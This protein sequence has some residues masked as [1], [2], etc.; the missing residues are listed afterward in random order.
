MLA[1]EY[2]TATPAAIAEAVGAAYDLDVVGGVF[3]VRGFNDTYE[4]TLSDGRQVMARLCDHRYR[5]PANVDFETAFMAHL[6]RSGVLVGAPLAACDGSLWRMV[7]AAE[8]PRELAV[9]RKLGGDMALQGWNPAKAP[10]D[11]QLDDIRLLGASHAAIHTAGERFVGPPSL[12]QLDGPFFLRDP[13][14]LAL[15]APTLDADTGHKLREVGERAAARIEAIAGDLSRVICH[16]DN[17]SANSFIVEDADGARTVGWFDFD[18]CGPGFLA[19]DLC[20][21]LWNQFRRARAPTLNENGLAVWRVFI[22]GYRSQRPIPEADY[23][24]II[25]MVVL[26]EIWLL[27]NYASRIPQW[28]QLS[29]GADFFRDSLKLLTAWETA[30]TPV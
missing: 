27:A 16:A 23:A 12:Y 7:E 30:E 9:F 5:G 17:H 25:T 26:R 2:S 13:L 1:A 14:A 29:V 24:A 15:G 21:L 8:G 18:D 19:Y 22:E 4:L 3:V 20:V 28:G 10:T 6:D 11:R